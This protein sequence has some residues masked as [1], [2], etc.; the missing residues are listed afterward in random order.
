[1][2]LFEFMANH[3]ISVANA[4]IGN[5]DT[6]VKSDTETNTIN[7][8]PR[9]KITGWYMYELRKMQ[10]IPQKIICDRIGMKQ[11][12]YSHYENGYDQP[13]AETL[14]RLADAFL[15]TTDYIIGKKMHAETLPEEKEKFITYYKKIMKYFEEEYNEEDVEQEAN[16]FEERLLHINK[17]VEYECKR[18]STPKSTKLYGFRYK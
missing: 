14:S 6:I 16:L 4:E 2:N 3:P 7:I 8:V 13:K 1:M 15:V 18:N 9:K 10:S 17:T 5:G 11:T 12:Q